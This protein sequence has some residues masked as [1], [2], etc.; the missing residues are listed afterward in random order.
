MLR[1][2]SIYYVNIW[3]LKSNLPW[4][5]GWTEYNPCIDLLEWLGIASDTFYNDKM[6]L[7]FYMQLS[8]VLFKLFWEYQVSWFS[9]Y[10]VI[11]WRRNSYLRGGWT[12]YNPWINWTAL[13]YNNLDTQII[14]AKETKLV[15]FYPPWVKVYLGSLSCIFFWS[16]SKGLV[17]FFEPPSHN[18]KWPIVSYKIKYAPKYT[19]VCRWVL[20]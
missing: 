11:I 7:L 16:W 3:R 14:P 12:E 20:F 4:R 1:I 17:L 5:G 8:S 2:I 9:I 6:Y 15:L 19:Y 18:F 10:D 13:H